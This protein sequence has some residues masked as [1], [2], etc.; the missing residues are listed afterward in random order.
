MEK[1][2]A[3]DPELFFDAEEAWRDEHGN[4]HC[5]TCSCCSLVL[6]RVLP[7]IFIQIDELEGKVQKQY[8]LVC[9][10]GCRRTEPHPQRS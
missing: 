2:V 4:L 1:V 10:G 9:I 5:P 7:S 3:E 8:R 6:A